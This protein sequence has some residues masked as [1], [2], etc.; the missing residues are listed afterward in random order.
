[1]P[2]AP[3]FVPVEASG[4][5]PSC[6][7][8]PLIGGSVQPLPPSRPLSGFPSHPR[9]P[10][11]FGAS[12]PPV[13]PP[14]DALFPRNLSQEEAYAHL[15][16]NA[17]EKPE[18]HLR[19]ATWRQFIGL[20]RSRP[21]ASSTLLEEADGHIVQGVSSTFRVLPPSRALRNSSSLKAVTAECAKQIDNYVKL[22]VVVRLPSPP[23]TVQPLHVVTKEGKELR[24]VLDLARNFNDYLEKKSFKL[25][26]INAAVDWSVPFCW[27]G[28]LDL[29]KCFL[30]FPLSQ[31]LRELMNFHFEGEY[32]RYDNMPFGLSTAPRIASLL[33][34][35]VSAQ[36]HE[37]GVR[38]VRY[39]DDWLLI[40][41]SPQAVLDGMLA[42]A[43][44]FVQFGLVLNKDKIEGPSQVMVF[45]GVELDSTKQSVGLSEQRVADTIALIQS[46]LTR[47]KTSRKVLQSL[48]GKLS[49]VS[50]CLPA[51]RPFLRSVIDLTSGP[52]FKAKPRRLS[53]DFKEEL[54]FWLTHLQSW[55]RT[56][57]WAATTVP[58]CF[59]S[60]ASTEG[61]GW[62]VESAPPCPLPLPLEATPGSAF[63]GTWTGPDKDRQASHVTIAF[64]ELFAAVSAVLTAGAALQDSHV[65]MVLDNS[66]DV[67]I[68]NRRAT[69]APRLLGLLKILARQSVRYNFTF[70]A[71]H[72][73]G[74]KNVLPDVLSRPTKHNNVLIP[75]AINA[76]VEAEVKANALIPSK[77]PVS[78]PPPAPDPDTA[79]S[80][81]S[82]FGS[83]FRT[84]HIS[85]IAAS[86][87]LMRAN[88]VRSVCSASLRSA[89][90]KSAEWVRPWLN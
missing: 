61:F 31:R 80:P 71:V 60:D 29:S 42:A 18:V 52:V 15:R 45:L 34:D 84:D 72:R 79:F 85:H 43:A 16:A 14:P 62:V 12:D 28:K 26:A 7:I 38:C 51:A 20:L 44:L 82:P 37:F 32:Y 73:A 49:F 21:G 47:K 78:P 77:P 40:G 89:F 8:P 2:P 27:Y 64:G 9:S 25:L 13:A 83:F 76:I 75:A 48:L 55:N 3:A 35:V 19:V 39:L 11:H 65:V 23:S 59:A 30:S 54:S 46:F 88:S 58:F 36:L 10:Y 22:G 81:P 86:K 56:Q 57:K 24:I 66:T 90:Q 70:V 67:A 69:N 87:P 5:P 68:V 53:A 17:L 33:L 6:S 1:M 63:S 41:A 4:D 50:S 74:C